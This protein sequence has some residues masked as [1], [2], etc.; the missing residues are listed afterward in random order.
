M[1]AKV[2]AV[3]YHPLRA[4]GWLGD[5]VRKSRR[6]IGEMVPPSEIRASESD[7]VFHTYGRMGSTKTK[8]RDAVVKAGSRTH[9]TILVASGPIP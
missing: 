5:P 6:H 9:G 3:C 8:L 1:I 7:R 2:V 4:E